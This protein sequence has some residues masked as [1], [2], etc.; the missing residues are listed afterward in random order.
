MDDNFLRVYDN[1]A[2][3]Q[4]S[5]VNP[6]PLVKLNKINSLPITLYAKLEWHNPFG[7]VKDRIAFQ[8]IQDAEEKGLLQDKKII[9]PTSGNTGIGL[10]A[11]ANIK[12]YKIRTTISSAIPDEK[13]NILRFLG[14]E[15]IEVAD[16]LCPDPNEPGGAIGIAKSTVKNLPAKFYM[17]NQ[18]ENEANIQ[19]H[20]LTTGPEI[21]KQTKGQI[22][23][24]AAGLGTCGTIGGVGQ[25]LK[26]KNKN[27]KIIAV[28]PQENHDIPGVRSLKQLNVTKL[29]KPDLY[30]DII[31]VSNK[32]AYDACLRLNREES[33]I[34]GPSSGMVIAGALKSLKDVKEGCVVC[35]FPDNIFKYTSFFSKNFPEIM[36]T[37]QPQPSNPMAEQLFNNMVQT[38][39]NENTTIEIDAAKKI[40]DEQQP[41]VI[42]VRPQH[43]YAQAHIPNAKNTPIAQITQQ[44][45]KLP[46]DK[47]ALILTVC[48]RGNTSLIGMIFLRS[49]GYTNVKSINNG[50][51]AWIEKGYDTEKE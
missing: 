17:P 36:P 19:A 24:F 6:T 32:E 33:I 28:H 25:Y 39:R 11:V 21:W 23:H 35:I 22:T 40:I 51:Q 46:T 26:E 44:K 20:Y 48:Q 43:I 13:K 29:F 42:D 8:L 14:A 16:T 50:T 27:I 34:A 30:D 38:A 45:N 9:E 12:N 5:V 7:A 41:L 10:T 18:Y 37:A 31:E 49:M 15:V 4:S 2:G 1:I 47:N 3:L